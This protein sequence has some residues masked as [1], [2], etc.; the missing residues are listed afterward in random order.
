MN[1]L[2][3]SEV[4]IDPMWIECTHLKDSFFEIFAAFTMV[5][6]PLSIPLL[7]DKTKFLYFVQSQHV[8][9]EKAR[10]QVSMVSNMGISC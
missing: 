10:A 2:V 8:L 5:I 9:Y 1:K 3:K 7:F 4:F 6:Q